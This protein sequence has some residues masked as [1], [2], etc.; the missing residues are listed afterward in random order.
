MA[1]SPADPVIARAFGGVVIASATAPGPASH[2]DSG[3]RF[4]FVPPSGDPA[5]EYA[6][7]IE[8][9]ATPPPH[10]LAKHF[11]AE[12]G[13]FFEIWTTLEVVAKLAEIPVFELVQV[14]KLKHGMLA[15]ISIERCDTD[16]HWIA[17]GKKP[18]A[19][20]KR[21]EEKWEMK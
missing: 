15:S 2:D 9:R 5:A 19:G 13:A 12:A 17:I 1:A 3:R 10:Y 21:T 14:R 6:L 16:T 11:A 18:T 7:D 8:R 20:T 4:V